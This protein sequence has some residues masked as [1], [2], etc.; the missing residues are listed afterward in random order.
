MPGRSSGTGHI[1]SERS[2]RHDGVAVIDGRWAPGE[3]LNEV[4]IAEELGVSRAPVREALRTLGEQGLVTHLPRVGS[5]VNE[6]TPDTVAHV[7]TLRAHIERW[8]IAESTELMTEEARAQLPKL[9]EQMEAALAATDY[10]AFYVV[11]WHMR[12][13]I[14]ACHPNKVAVDEIKRLRARL[15]NLPNVLHSVPEMAEWT[16]GMHRKMVESILAG[17]GDTAGGL[18]AAMLLRTS[19]L[20]KEAYAARL[21]KARLDRDTIMRSGHFLAGL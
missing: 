3:R 21:E 4:H 15:H 1:D 19:E 13:V 8:L 20:V 12:D 17:D 16:F 2:A 6:F 18:I 9:L 7:Y 5:V 10:P 14:Y 11:T